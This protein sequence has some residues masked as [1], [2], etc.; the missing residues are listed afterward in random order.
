MYM[1]RK[2]K[3]PVL[4]GKH[5]PSREAELVHPFI[6]TKAVFEKFAKLLDKPPADNPPLR[7]LLLTKAPWD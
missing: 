1:P 4:G 5:T 3:R 7:R 6:V 2:R